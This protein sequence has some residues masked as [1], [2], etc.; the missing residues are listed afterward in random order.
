MT[1]LLWHSNA[2]FAPTGYGAQTALFQPLLAQEF[3]FA[4]SAFYG[5]EAAPI[6]YDGTRIYP[7]TAGTFGDENLVRHAEHFFGGDARGG[8]VVTLMDVWVLNPQWMKQLNLACWVPV[9]HDPAP[10]AVLEFFTLSG[11]VPIAMSKFGLSMLGRLDPLYVPHAVDTDV[12]RPRDRRESR[13]QLG[14]GR[15]PDNAF[16]VGMVAANKGRPSRKCFSQA[17]Q[18]FTKFARQHEDAYLYL[19]TTVDPGRA[20]GEDIPAILSQ[21][22]LPADRVLIPDQYALNFDPVSH[23]SMARIYSAMDVLMNPSMGEGFGIPIIEAQACG[24]PVIVTDFTA[25]V[26]L[27]GAGWKVDHTR[28]WTGQNSWQTVPD[29]D[30]IAG[31]LE[32]CHAL[33][34]SRRQRLSEIARKHALEYSLPRVWQAY[35]LPALRQIEKRFGD[36]MPITIAPRHLKVAAA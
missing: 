6:N 23:D 31:A 16:L 20:V 3:E 4:I 24:V 32:E 11:A 34:H 10:P 12:F 13:R 8:L 36:Q 27:C 35:M 30:D 19:H 18:A 15:L 33:S 28:W 5:L 21:M 7:G 25:M 17:I 1:K 14:G 26:E 2:P 29:I 9:D 22:G